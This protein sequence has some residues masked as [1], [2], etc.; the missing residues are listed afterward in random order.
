MFLSKVNK[1][2]QTA[3]VVSKATG[4]TFKVRLIEKSCLNPKYDQFMIPDGTVACRDC[5]SRRYYEKVRCSAVKK[6]VVQ[7]EEGEF[8]RVKRSSGYKYSEWVGLVCE[9][10]LFN[11]KSDAL[12]TIPMMFNPGGCKVV[13]V[14]VRVKL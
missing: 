11:R 4:E 7:N 1:V 2:G 6:Y 5:L 9:A 14:E 13:E 8:L 10:T 3:E 12:Q